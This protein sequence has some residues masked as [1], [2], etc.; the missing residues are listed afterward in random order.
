MKFVAEYRDA[1][2]AKQYVDAIALITTRLWAM[3]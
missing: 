3:M 1:D 2:L